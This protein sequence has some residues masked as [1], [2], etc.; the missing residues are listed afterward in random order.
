MVIQDVSQKNEVDAEIFPTNAPHGEPQLG[1]FPIPRLVDNESRPECAH[2]V[3]EDFYR[4]FIHLSQPLE[5]IKGCPDPL[6]IVAVHGLLDHLLDLSTDSHVH[7][8]VEEDPPDKLVGVF[9][10][11]WLRGDEEDPGVGDEEEVED[12]G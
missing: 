6:L 7:P 11:G 1:L 2:A 10:R 5:E 12:M 4:L 8:A 3:F 9:Q